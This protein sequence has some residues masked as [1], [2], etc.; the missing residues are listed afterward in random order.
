M[1]AL[2]GIFKNTD[3]QRMSLPVCGAVLIFLREKFAKVLGN[4]E[5]V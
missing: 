3:I 2:N 5:K 1:T 4:L